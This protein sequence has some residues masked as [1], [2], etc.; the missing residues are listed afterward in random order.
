MPLLQIY[1]A[2]YRVGAIAPSGSPVKT[3]TVEAA[4]CAMGQTFAALGYKDPRLQDTGKIDFRLHRQL[5]AYNKADPPPHRVK[6]VP[7][8]VIQ[9]AVNFC[10]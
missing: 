8:Q 6:P 9:Q 2:R 4:L 7:L 10:T 1:A 5:Q 3:Y